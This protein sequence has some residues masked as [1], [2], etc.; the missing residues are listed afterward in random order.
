[1]CEARH[2]FVRERKAY[3]GFIAEARSEKTQVCFAWDSQNAR[4]GQKVRW[5]LY[6]IYLLWSGFGMCGK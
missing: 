2:F 4:V 3:L 6:D 5:E 1:L